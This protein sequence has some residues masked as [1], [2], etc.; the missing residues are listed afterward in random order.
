LKNQPIPNRIARIA[1][2]GLVAAAGL[3]VTGAAVPAQASA[4]PLVDYHRS[5][6]FAGVQDRLS[7]QPDGRVSRR[8]RSGEC[9]STLSAQELGDLRAALDQAGFASLQSSPRP[10]GNDFFHYT[11]T[12]Q[13]RT[14]RTYDTVVPPSLKPALT[15]LN[16]LVSRPCAESDV[17]ADAEE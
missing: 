2:I 13:G 4:L 17:P 14:V 5:G 16:A 1:R 3:A 7:V 8:T 11:V 12:Y 10:S 6:G 9:A 15:R